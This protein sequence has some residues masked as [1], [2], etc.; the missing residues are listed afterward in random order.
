MFQGMIKNLWKVAYF[1]NHLTLQAEN[2]C[3]F[4]RKCV[5]GG[6]RDRFSPV[7]VQWEWVYFKIVYVFWPNNEISRQFSLWW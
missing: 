1:L 2:V 6:G 4:V 3:L 7:V 5:G